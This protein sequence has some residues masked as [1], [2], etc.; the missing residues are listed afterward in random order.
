MPA[1]S[2]EA[3]LP[4]GVARLIDVNLN[5][6]REGL[7][8][9]EETARYVW[10][11]AA[12]YRRLRAV[13]HALDRATRRRYAELVGARDSVRDAGRTLKEIG[14]R[15][16]VAAVAAANMRRAQEAV[17]VLEEYGKMISV[18]AA[19]DFK[20]LRYRLY[21]EEKRFLNRS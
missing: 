13:R 2:A 5:R 18:G 10:G 9:V 16:S 3:P 12:L 14:R 11:D 8:T 4:A 20:R 19:A 7:R 21:Q 1:R 6:A 15:E 17:R